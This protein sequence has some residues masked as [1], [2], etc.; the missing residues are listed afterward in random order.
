MNV[1]VCESTVLFESNEGLAATRLGALV[2]QEVL[3]S[4]SVVISSVKSHDRDYD[5]LLRRLWFANHDIQLFSGLL[6]I[7]QDKAHILEGYI[8]RSQITDNVQNKKVS[9]RIV[10]YVNSDDNVQIKL[11]IVLRIRS[12]WLSY[13]ALDST[14]F[15]CNFNLC[16]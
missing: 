14:A 3:A 16:L 15:K 6:I 9:K 4:F 1:W 5:L 10:I 2:F 8:S 12:T 11:Y 13:G 7:M